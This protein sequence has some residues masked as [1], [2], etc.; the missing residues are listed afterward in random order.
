M[1]V[2]K[3]Y[4]EKYGKV[5]LVLVSFLIVVFLLIFS[6]IS[7]SDVVDNNVTFTIQPVLDSP[8]LTLP[9][10]TGNQSPE[11]PVQNLGVITTILTLAANKIT[12]FVGD[13]IHIEAILTYENS[14][15]ISDKKI[16]FYATNEVIG[17]ETTNAEGDTAV[18]WDTTAWL[19]EVYT[20][21]AHYAGE[22]ILG[23][24]N[25]EIEIQLKKPVE[26]LPKKNESVP[27][28]EPSVEPI[29]Q[30]D[31]I[32]SVSS[33]KDVLSPAVSDGEEVEYLGYKFSNH[34]NVIVSTKP[35][36]WC[37]WKPD[38]E[39][40]GW[41]LCEAVFEIKNFNKV[42][43][44]VRNPVIDFDFKDN[45]IKNKDIHFSSTFSVVDEEIN[46]DN[47]GGTKQVFAKRKFNSFSA[48]PAEIDTSQSF[49]LRII[50]E[51]P[52]YNSNQFNLGIS[53]GD[54]KGFIDPVQSSCGS[55]STPGTY[56]LSQNI[57][58]NGTCFI[59]NSNSVVLDGAGFTILGNGSGIGIDDSNG[60][61]NVTIKNFGGISNFT[62]GVS[63]TGGVNVSVSKNTITPANVSLGYGIYFVSSNYSSV[64]SNTI[65]TAGS[66]SHG[67]FIEQFSVVNLVNSNTITT[68]GDS[69]YSV[70]IA[71]GSD[72]NTITSNTVNTSSGS[73]SGVRIS[74]SNSSTVSSNIIYTSGIGGYAV[75]LL[76]SGN[77]V[78]LN[79]ELSANQSYEVYMQ[80]TNYVN[81]LIYNTS[82]GEI[83]WINDS[84]GGFLQ[85]LTLEGTIG[86]NTNLFIGSNVASL[87][88]SAFT[89]GKVNSSA[90]I[91]L[92]SIGL[93][94]VEQVRKLEGY[95]T[96]SSFIINNGVNCAGSGCSSINYTDGVLTFNA[97]TLGSF[98]AYIN[99]T[100]PPSVMLINPL[101]NE[102][103]NTSGVLF[104]YNVTDPNSGI[105]NCSLF[106][107]N[108]L[109]QTD[110]PIIEM[111]ESFFYTDGFMDK[112]YGWYVQCLD[113]NVNANMN[114]SQTRIFTV[115][116]TTLPLITLMTPANN[117]NSSNDDFV[118]EY[119]VYDS[120]G[121]ENCSLSFNSSIIQTDLGVD[122]DLNNFSVYNRTSGHYGWRVSCTDRSPNKNV[123]TST[124][125]I[126]NISIESVPPLITLVSP[127]NASRDYDGTV[128]FTFNVTDINNRS[129]ISSC[130]LIINGILNRSG[131][132]FV[133]GSSQIFS[134]NLSN[135]NYWW[136]VSCTDD[137][138]N[139]A[140]SASRNVTAAL[141]INGPAIT[142]LSPPNNT[143]EEK[144]NS[145]IFAYDVTDANVLSNCS[146]LVDSVMLVT[147]S[148]PKWGAN[149]ITA[150]VA[151]GFHNWS[152]QCVDSLANT[153]SSTVRNLSIDT[154][155]LVTLAI[156]NFYSDSDGNTHFNFTV[157]DNI[158][159]I[160]C[161][162]YTTMNGTW[163]V[164]LTSTFIQPNVTLSFPVKRIRDNTSFTWNILCIDSDFNERW[165]STNYT[166]II[167]NTPPAL[168]TIPALSWGED[169]YTVVNLSA[170][171]SDIDGDKIGYSS[172]SPG[173]I[174]V[175][176]DNST[177]LVNLESS[178]NWY[179]TNSIIFTASDGI[180]NTTSNTVSITVN[181]L[182][183][184]SPRFRSQTPMNDFT[185]GDGYLFLG[186]SV[187]DDYNLVNVSLYHNIS[188]TWQVNQTKNIM[189]TE[190]SVVFN[191]TGLPNER[192]Y[193][194]N[195]L[196]YDNQS[197]YVWG[198]NRAVSVGINVSIRHTIPNYIVNNVNHTRSIVTSYSRYLNDSLTLGNLT[199]L[200]MDDNQVY[201]SQNMSNSSSYLS[202]GNTSIVYP[203][204]IVF[205][206]DIFDGNF[207]IGNLA[208]LN[209][210]LTYYY[211][212]NLYKSYNNVTIQ[213]I[214]GTLGG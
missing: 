31:S 142:L 51:A 136:S 24:G 206:D 56:T 55:L 111:L 54:F 117:T 2:I 116:D 20:I 103:K 176:I 165:A 48:L 94:S 120:A 73:A 197:Q 41:K 148:S 68:T 70:F 21:S 108:T 30:N 212:S 39:D 109:N 209:I 16:D 186:C 144:N 156:P 169:N 151:N 125:F 95:S 28:N 78:I 33:D 155:P 179:G 135:G 174:T 38:T 50:Y 80:G 14:T 53:E 126:L 177:G 208:R 59:I 131:S 210:T 10:E 58:V 62:T 118:F 194:W 168:S 32:I 170:Y 134:V 42:S 37:S 189:G 154:G 141:D 100:T 143:L 157:T 17:S 6:V 185:D 139:E 11:P 82:L 93:S 71:T 79:N 64:S 46:E 43:T 65:T 211:Q 105:A 158:G 121:I 187:T 101:N 57:T 104:I 87:N 89:I 85:N 34:S 184:T 132:N 77:N 18:Q 173:N 128:D 102:L 8:I 138:W 52:K 124:T 163:E 188:G 200:E 160:N 1:G 205:T 96:D 152:I 69:S 110:A 26:E 196:A 183:D 4:E 76:D 107:N 172:T 166:L 19:P 214:N 190:N 25:A 145:I 81:Y 150:I 9:I 27:I 203:K 91:T 175:L 181:Q 180:E 133:E 202:K 22:D 193:L 112:D 67:V 90:R 45:A 140:G 167:N 88:T 5:R 29:G 47:D 72:S 119:D 191:V 199:I 61:D 49:A 178:K 3:T 75:S 98:S 92:K 113:N 192:S 198:E 84:T 159:L 23:A 146:I 44:L 213:V 137:F 40:D 63:A 164:N 36:I 182:G 83:R 171:F 15:P 66:S 147:N 201:F 161:S 207:T 129:G 115:R 149:N 7:S 204:S 97:T 35:V 162:L 130:K 123:G 114:M 153:G 106:I 12:A 74:S 122:T 86:L 13:I 195:C 60:F 127:A 99:D